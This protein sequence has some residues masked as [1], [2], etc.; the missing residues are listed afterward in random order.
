MM[1]ISNNGE[2]FI[3]HEEGERLTAYLDSVGIWTIGVG[4]TGGVDGQ[5]IR[6]GMKIT[7][8]KSREL[9]HKDI[10]S[11]EIAINANV[12]VKLNQNQF[13]ALASLIFNIGVG[14]FKKSTLLRALNAGDYKA[15]AAQFLAWKYAGGRPILLARRQREQALFL[16]G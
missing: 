16:R 4:H 14:N 1:K 5:P 8:L 7:Q 3:V 15:A 13:D 11:A 9:L 6:Q 10:A 12:R 2:Q